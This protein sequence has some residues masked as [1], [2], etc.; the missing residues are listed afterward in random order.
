MNCPHAPQDQAVTVFSRGWHTEI[1]IPAAALHGKLALFKQVFPGA[2]TVVFGY[3]KRTFMSAHADKLAEYLVGPV[4]GPALIEAIG[5]NTTVEAAYG[6]RDQASVVLPPAGESALEDFIWDDL[7]KDRAGQP[8]LV[9]PGAFQGSLFY[10]AISTYTL[11]HTCNAWVAQAL[12]AA[13][14]AISAD[15]V[16]FSGQV[17][18]RMC[19]TK[20]LF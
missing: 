11:G 12:H 1:G 4:P 14:L 15:S 6:A 5:L 2:R 20:A 10:A 13:G 8:K 19:G 17:M 9:G 7:E 16:V 3:G 18:G